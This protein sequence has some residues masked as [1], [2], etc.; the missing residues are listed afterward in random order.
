MRK[1]RERLERIQI[2]A[3]Q[4]ADRVWREQRRAEYENL[5]EDARWEAAARPPPQRHTAAGA[6]AR[7]QA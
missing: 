6:A 2:K 4:E 7:A 5:G 1:E 3:E